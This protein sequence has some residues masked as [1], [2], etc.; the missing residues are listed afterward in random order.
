QKN[1][2][3]EIFAEGVQEFNIKIFN[4]RGQMVYESKDFSESWNGQ[5]LNDG[6]DCP[7]GIY[8]YEVMVR[9]FNRKKYNLKGRITI[10][11]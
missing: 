4:Q 3:F 8:V 11:R 6:A 5:Y 2:R 1:D 7:S 10:L 9:D